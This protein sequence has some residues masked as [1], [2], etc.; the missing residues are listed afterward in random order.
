MTDLPTSLD[1]DGVCQFWGGNQPLSRA[2]IY[3]QITRGEHPKPYKNGAL[4]RWDTDELL[5]ERARRMAARS[6]AA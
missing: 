1:I 4:S 2:T 6:E 5:A 3:R